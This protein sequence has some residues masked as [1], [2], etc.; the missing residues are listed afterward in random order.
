M[1]NQNRVSE[2]SVSPLECMKEASRGQD[3]RAKPRI[4]N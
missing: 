1:A 2:H 3:L 4:K